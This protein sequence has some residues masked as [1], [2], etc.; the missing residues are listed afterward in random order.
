MNKRIEFVVRQSAITWHPLRW[1][2]TAGFRHSEVLKSVAKV[3]WSASA[4]RFTTI[5]NA[6]VLA[7]AKNLQCP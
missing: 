2:E 3:H 7:L 1:N 6:L 5:G 4:W